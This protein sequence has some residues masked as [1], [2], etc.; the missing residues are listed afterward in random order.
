MCVNVLV[1]CDLAA[2]QSKNDTK[3]GNGPIALTNRVLN[4]YFVAVKKVGKETNTLL[5]PCYVLVTLS[6]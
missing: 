5:T 4:K 1:N 3:V 6:V 2:S